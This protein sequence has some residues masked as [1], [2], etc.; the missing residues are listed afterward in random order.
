RIQVPR[1]ACDHLHR[2]A[3]N[4]S[5]PTMV[6]HVCELLRTPQMRDQTAALVV[7]ATGVG[8]AVLDLFREA[9]DLPTQVIAVS[10]TSGSEPRVDETGA[11]YWV[12]KRDLVS[13]LQV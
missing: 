12:T 1:Y 3:L 2:F 11:N 8:G 6:R 4:T 9:P 7:D 5:Y 13:V 10:I